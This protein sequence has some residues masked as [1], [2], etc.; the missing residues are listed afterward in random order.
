MRRLTITAIIAIVFIL[1]TAP[2]QAFACSCVDI[3][4]EEMFEIAEEVF[5]GKV[6]SIQ[7]A[8]NFITEFLS[9]LFRKHPTP[10]HYNVTFDI[11]SR[12]KGDNT[13]TITIATA[14]LSPACGFSFEESKEYLV[15]ANAGNFYNSEFSTSICSRTQL[16]EEAE[17][18][19][20]LLGEAGVI[21]TWKEYKNLDLGIALIY[22]SDT[23]TPREIEHPQ[24]PANR[25]F[26]GARTVRFETADYDMD[27]YL[28]VQG[29]EA[30]NIETWFQN[31][32]D[33]YVITT[34]T[35]IAGTTG[36]VSEPKEV[37]KALCAGYNVD[38]MKNEYVYSLIISCMSSVEDEVE[39]ITES[40]RFTTWWDTITR[41]ISKIFYDKK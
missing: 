23:L 19:L 24:S 28:W 14:K 9:G 30:P 31:K 35:T 12:W 15:Y 7:S 11:S 26:P 25:L 2:H 29:T 27:M 36:I 22:P 38:F 16:L 34:T 39:R 4:Q 6:T 32:E 5:V 21:H 8:G 37:G 41:I 13:S 33:G 1:G 10:S 17:E 18:E 40:V 3:S 20:K